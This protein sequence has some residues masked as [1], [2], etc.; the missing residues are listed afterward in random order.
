MQLFIISQLEKK[1]QQIFLKNIPELLSQLRKVLRV[2]VGDTIFVQLEKSD[3]NGKFTRYQL[4]IT[5]RTDKDLIGEIVGEESL[6]SPKWVGASMLIA[7]PNKREKAE[8]IV[9]KLAEIG[10]HEIVFRPAERS[11]IKQWNEKKAERLIKIAKEAVEQSRGYQL[12]RISWCNEV[13]KYCEGK[14]VGIFDII[15]HTGTSNS[16]LI[17]S[18]EGSQTIIWVVG[19]EGGLTERD[20]QLFEQYEIIDLGETV[21]RMETAAIIGGWK[22]KNF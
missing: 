4:R 11:V 17:S 10:I 16:E 2:K 15:P 20:Y 13:K 6:I 22:L 21:L 5:E 1:N 9:Q 19:P 14:R 12:P 3:S 7:M 18:Q 8:L